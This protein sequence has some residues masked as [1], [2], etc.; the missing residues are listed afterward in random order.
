MLQKGKNL[1]FDFSYVSNFV[2][3]REE[4]KNFIEKNESKIKSLINMNISESDV[5]GWIRIIDNPDNDLIE[6]IKSKAEEIRNNADIFLI[7]GVGGSNRGAQAVINALSFMKDNSLKPKIV[8]CGN[9]LSAFYLNSILKELEGK[10]VY[11]NIIAKNFATLEPNITF[12]IVRDYMEKIYGKKDVAKR[13]IATGSPNDSDLEILAKNKGYTFLPFPLDVGGRF[14]VFSSVGL[15]PIAAA[16]IDIKMLLEGAK[17]ERNELK[18]PDLKNNP[19]VLYAV[20][21]NILFEKGYV[22]EIL[23]YFEPM[24]E[25][26]ALWWVQLFGESEGKK[27]KGIFPASC[28]FTE[29]LH[30]LGQYIQE[31]KRIIIETFIDIEKPIDNLVI[32]SGKENEDQYNYLTNHELNDLNKIAFQGTI[33]AHSN[34]GIPCININI[35]ELNEYFL[36]QLLFF[37]EYSCYISASIL[38][39]NPFNQPGVEAYKNNMFSL[40]K[41]LK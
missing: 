19:A 30:S 3:D 12:R 24:L 37:F 38:D 22:I 40:L 11:C 9:N 8:Y 4:T 6:Q 16:G 5:L 15:L 31:G 13:I 39:V 28:N 2:S 26:F 41:K 21:R 20:K 35:P 23:S 27:G 29:D 17:K 10:S 33:K 18:S 25:S 36:G 34:G 7:I 14:S 1:N 32:P